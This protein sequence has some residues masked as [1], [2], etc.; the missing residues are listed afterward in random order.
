V[1]F[2]IAVRVTG[3]QGNAE[4]GT[5][6]ASANADIPVVGLAA[7]GVIGPVNVW[8][9]VNDDQN[10]DWQ[11]ISTAQSPDWGALP[12]TQLPSWTPIAS[13]QDPEWDGVSEIQNPDWH[14]VA[15]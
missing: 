10:P 3:L 8:G 12:D 14:N 7:I 4:L 9:V 2:G 5:V 6:A 11:E 1:A 15:A 13:T